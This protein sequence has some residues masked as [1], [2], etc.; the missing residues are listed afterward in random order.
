MSASRFLRRVVTALAAAGAGLAPLAAS[1]QSLSLGST[2]SRTHYYHD[3]NTTRYWISYRDCAADDALT[4][5]VVWT[6]LS[7]A[8]LEV[9]VGSVNCADNANRQTT[10]LQCWPV[11]TRT[12]FETTPVTVSLSVR[13]IIAQRKATTFDPTAAS[14]AD[15]DSYTGSTEPAPYDIYFL[16]VNSDGTT[17]TAV[18]AVKYSIKIDLLGPEPP[19]DLTAG[20]GESQLIVKF[21][22]SISNDRTGYRVY[23]DDGTVTDAGAGADA[24]AT[25]DAGGEC[26]SSLLIPGEIPPASLSACGSAS[27]KT[28]TELGATSLDNGQSYVVAVS[29]V[30]QVGNAGE[31]SELACGTPQPVTDFFEAYRDAGGKAGG[32]FCSVSRR[33]DAQGAWLGLLALAGLALS[34]RRRPR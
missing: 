12:P 22:G 31:L 9:W 32:G 14:A 6:G 18:S 24:G 19:T 15:C 13:D 25:V 17:N 7:A 2:V 10:T 20:I 21:K 29:A 23:C 16:P 30:D 8:S 4:F 34:A 26:S 11:S 33:S 28:V 1:A 27:G 3:D 5:Q